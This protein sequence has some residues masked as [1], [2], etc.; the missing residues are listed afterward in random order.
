MSLSSP[1][2]DL[3]L[4]AGAVIALTVLVIGAKELWTWARRKGRGDADEPPDE[5]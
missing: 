1:G 5:P 4:A 3:L 2:F